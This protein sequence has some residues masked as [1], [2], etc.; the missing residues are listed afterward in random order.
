METLSNFLGGYITEASGAFQYTLSMN[1]PHKQDSFNPDDWDRDT[2]VQF[3]SNVTGSTDKDFLDFV[4][5]MYDD[6]AV[7][8]DKDYSAVPF[9]HRGKGSKEI[10][11][12]DIYFGAVDDADGA[13]A[14][15]KNTVH[16]SSFR[17][18]GVKIIKGNG[19]GGGLRGV[20]FE[21]GLYEGLLQYV[22]GGCNPDNLEVP[23]EV[24]SGLKNLVRNKEMADILHELY[25]VVNDEADPVQALRDKY[26]VSTGSRNAARGIR[27]ILDPS[28]FDPVK[29]GEQ[30]AD[31]TIHSVKG[32]DIYL[33]I[34]RNG[35]NS[36]VVVDTKQNGGPW[37]ADILKSSR[38]GGTLQGSPK[39]DLF[40]N[41]WSTLGL[42]PEEVY[43][44][45]SK[46]PSDG[47]LPLSVEN[48]DSQRVTDV[49]RRL[50]GA[51]YW[52][53]TP[54]YSFYIQ[55]L[56]G[57]FVPDPK[58]TYITDTGKTIQIGGNIGSERCKIK[59]RTDGKGE[60]PRR[61]FVEL[62]VRELFG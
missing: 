11:L 51:E 37:M 19:L 23:P 15:W 6:W 9:R 53:V 5:E 17:V 29:P 3:L 56:N 36:G 22:A 25:D 4:G 28:R 60:F 42:D 31:I 62:N 58:N 40:R 30:I 26:I 44:Q 2:Y 45:Y 14:A 59:I 41:L 47:N 39:N 21:T 55:D 43:N 50:I 48:V 1:K 16:G 52:Y 49:I 35:Q 34:K 33:S 8:Y 7:D 10:K 18:G 61:L 54:E 12:A 46:T 57:T 13:K 32:R 24:R 20:E 38:S 27:S